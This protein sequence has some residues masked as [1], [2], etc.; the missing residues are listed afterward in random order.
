MT[1]FDI[2]SNL[3]KGKQEENKKEDD[4]L[5][6]ELIKE[7]KQEKKTENP[8]EKMKLI[9]QIQHF[10]KNK[11][12]G[13]YLKN[14][15]KHNFE[16]G[17]LRKLTIDELKLELEKQT[18]AL[19]NK[20]NNSLID[21]SLEKFIEFVENIVHNK[22]KLKIKGTTQKLFSDDHFLDLLEIIKLKYNIPFVKLDPV[23]EISLIIL[24][25]CFIQHQA[26]TFMINFK[27][28]MDLDEEI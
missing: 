10:G 20:N 4:K 26:N 28:S 8:T 5:I 7:D 19:S 13:E 16:E 3:K 27:P 24:Q 18:V 9:Y 21:S 1:D 2:F 14:E 15:C 11:R 25:T 17:Y 23:L 12:F 6:K 22:T